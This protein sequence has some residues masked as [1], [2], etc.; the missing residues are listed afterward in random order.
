MR[1]E[2]SQ[3]ERV[4]LNCYDQLAELSDQMLC[5]AR[6]SNWDGLSALEQKAQLVVN[7]LKAMA[8]AS[9]HSDRFRQEKMRL[10]RV[11][12]ALDA[13]IRDLVQPRLAQLDRAMRAPRT[14]RRLSAAYGCG[15]FE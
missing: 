7:D 2:M 6:Q 9:S 3:H 15:R 12:L 11:I 1:E 14:Q 13:Q 4:T 5:A 8:E 10:I